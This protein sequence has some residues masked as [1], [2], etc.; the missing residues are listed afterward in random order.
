M[1]IVNI[2]AIEENGSTTL[3]RASTFYGAP[4][5][6]VAEVV[7]ELAEVLKNHEDGKGQVLYSE[8][9]GINLIDTR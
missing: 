4:Q 5:G 6:T 8:E 3:V 1:T 2:L 7:A 9:L